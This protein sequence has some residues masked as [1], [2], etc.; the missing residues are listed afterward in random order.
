ML[1]EKYKQSRDVDMQ[2]RCY[3]FAALLQQPAVMVG[4]LPVDASCE[5]IEIDDGLDWLVNSL[6]EGK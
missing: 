3:E 6:R 4:V 5:D 2:Q 1:L